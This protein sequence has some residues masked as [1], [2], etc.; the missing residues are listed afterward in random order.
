MTADSSP[1]SVT[2]TK[3]THI[4]TYTH[5]HK[6]TRCDQSTAEAMAIFIFPNLQLTLTPALAP[7]SPLRHSRPTLGKQNETGGAAAIKKRFNFCHTEVQFCHAWESDNYPRSTEILQ[8]NQ[9]AALLIRS[10]QRQIKCI[11]DLC[12]PSICSSS[13]WGSVWGKREAAPRLTGSTAQSLS[14]SFFLPPP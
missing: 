4:H 2:T 5:V 3:H 13:P 1:F 7:R 9:W 8:I 12:N 6:P 10:G 14:S 11:I